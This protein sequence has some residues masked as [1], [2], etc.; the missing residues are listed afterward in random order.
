MM[1][2][3]MHTKKVISNAVLISIISMPLHAADL[4]DVLKYAQTNDPQLQAAGANL[5]S[6]KEYKSQAIAN[7]LPSIGASAS[8]SRNETEQNLDN[9]G[10]TTADYDSDSWAIQLTQPI[11]NKANHAELRQAKALVSQAQA[12]YEAAYQVFL[13][14][15]VET[16][17]MVITAEDSLEF[18]I[19][20][21]KAIG[22]E[23]DQAEQRFNVGLTAV[24]DVHEAK[25]RYDAAR[26]KVIVAQ[27]Q[28]DDAKEALNE[29]TNQYF[30]YLQ[31]LQNDLPLIPP[32]PQDLDDWVDLALTNNPSLHSYRAQAETARFSIGLARAGHYPTL[33]FTARRSNSTSGGA[34]G[35]TTDAT[36]YS[37][38][39]N[40]PIFQGGAVRSSVRQTQYNHEFALDQL[41]QQRRSVIRQTRNAYRGTLAS[42]SEV[43]ARRQ[44]LISAESAVE[45][46][47]AGFEV[48]TRTIV[49]TLL[50]Q[51]QLFQAQRDYSES[52]HNYILNHM[53]LKLAAGILNASDLQAI[54]QFLE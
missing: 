47:E 43:E 48:G 41:E 5:K 14:R 39:L 53:R 40:V 17:F 27:N 10:S 25:A 19:A 45:A 2:F 4:L 33:D 29:L 35:G 12:D 38:E 21:E 46:T 18:A 49:D 16:Y 11:F 54:N 22:R 52:R 24:T 15:T 6:N 32:K 3:F 51:Q 42:I 37:L 9:F 7:F 36:I 26:A 34:F 44:A 30:E 50:S 8:E 23:L 1:N 13:L 20:E 28:V 31:P